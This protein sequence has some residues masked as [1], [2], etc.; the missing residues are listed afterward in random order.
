M[1]KIIKNKILLSFLFVL[2]LV[3]NLAYADLKPNVIVS[4]FAIKEGAYVGR[5]F[6][7]SAKLIN[8]EPYS[9]AKS[10]TT[11]IEAG[12]PFVMEGISTFTEGDICYGSS[13]T[14]EFPLK[15]DSTAN[16][17]FYQVK[18]KNNYESTGYIQFSASATLNLFVNGSPEINANIIN[19]EPIDIYPGD[20]GTLTLKIE[21]HGTFQ[22]QS[23]SAVMKANGPI[24]VKWAKSFNS[25]EVLEPRESKTIEF[26]V[27][28]PK[29]AEAKIYPLT[30]ELSYYDENKAKQQKTFNFNLYVKK[31][32]KFET[33]DAGS[34]SMYANQNLRSVKINLKNTGTDAARKIKAKII[35]QFPFSTDGS[36][37]YIEILDVSKSE[38]IDFKVDVDKD[39]NIG[40]YS[41]D[42]LVGFED[43]QERAF[44][45][46][47]HIVLEVKPKGII[48][49]VFI[50]YWFLWLIA[51]VVGALVFRKK[52]QR[53]KK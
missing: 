50:D 14:V 8:T 12:F 34:D 25:I 35:P 30:M 7:L 33:H 6:I 45:D 39:A 44:Q 15:V 2:I 20:T 1:K 23:L 10:V 4:E 36:V 42:L 3:A 31:K 51:L 21:N 27:E 22:A 11:S 5:E 37:R 29:N 26:A 18:I 53:A 16:G 47:A 28:V 19:S 9:C 38:A 32:A 49:A 41:L 17:G 43:A 24:E 46:T 13:K 52:F 40:K 48:R